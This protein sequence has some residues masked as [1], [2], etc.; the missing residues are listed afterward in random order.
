MFSLLHGELTHRIDKLDHN[1]VKESSTSSP[2][3]EP[4]YR[5]GVRMKAAVRVDDLET[6]EPIVVCK[7]HILIIP[8]P[9]VYIYIYIYISVVV[10][11]YPNNNILEGNAPKIKYFEPASMENSDLLFDVAIT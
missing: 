4:F 1:Q 7:F 6:V 5:T 3:L 2:I 8:D 9:I 10:Q 11:S